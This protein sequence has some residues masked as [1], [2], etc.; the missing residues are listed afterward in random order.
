MQALLGSYRWGW[1]DLRG[2][3]PALAAARL[4][5]RWAAIDEVYGRSG[6]LRR[7]CE[8]AG[9]AYVAVIPCDFQVTT[10]A[11]TVIRADQA[12]ADAVFERRSAGTGTKGPRIS[13][14][15]MIATASPRHFLLIRRLLSRPDQLTRRRR[16]RQ[17]PQ[18][19]RR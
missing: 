18:R 17:P 14:W 11:R 4:P 9:L 8:R 5:A 7:A 16:A 13:D 3:L 10:P 15:A 1:Q 2:E 6:K 19:R 12:A